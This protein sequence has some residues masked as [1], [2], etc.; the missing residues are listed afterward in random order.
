MTINGLLL[1]VLMILVTRKTGRDLIETRSELS[2]NML[3]TFQGLE[4]LQAAGAQNHWLGQ[5]KT[6]DIKE[7][8]LNVFTVSCLVSIQDWF[9]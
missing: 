2:S 5:A 9:F 3:E 4:D 7:T 1:P 6:L 8:Q